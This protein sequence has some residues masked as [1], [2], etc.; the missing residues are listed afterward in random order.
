VKQSQLKIF[1]GVFLLLSLV[2]IA[3]L[4]RLNFSYDFEQFFPEGDEDLEFF[5]EFRERFEAD[6]NFMLFA[7]KNE[8]GIFEGDFLSKFEN[9]TKACSDL[10]FVTDV[11]SLA[12]LKL[13]TRTPFGFS[14]VSLI[15]PGEPSKYKQDQERIKKYDELENVLYS[16]DLKSVVI[17]C[18]TTDSVGIGKSTELIPAIHELFEPYDF[19]SYYLLGRANFQYVLVKMQKREFLISSIVSFALLILFMFI[20]FKEPLG[21]LI[22]AVSVIVSMLLF[23]GFMLLFDREFNAISALYPILLLI[24]S[25]SDVVHLLSKYIDEIELGKTNAEAINVTVKEIGRA[26]F[27]TSTTTAAGF[28]SLST[29]K[30]I[31]IREF[32]VNAAVGVLIAYITVLLFTTGLLSIFGNKRKMVIR[33]NKGFWERLMGWFSKTSLNRPRLIVWSIVVVLLFCAYG[34][35]QVSTNYS[36]AKNLPKADNI[37]RDFAFFE[38]HFGGFRP[39]EFSIRSKNGSV[40]EFEQ[41]EEIA[42]LEQHVKK[43]P[44]IE[45]VASVVQPFR[46]LNMALRNQNVAFNKL[47]SD[48]LAYSQQRQLIS[49]FAGENLG[50]LVSKDQTYGRI[51]TRVG[52]IGADSIK[53]I[54][55]R[56]D[57]W[58]DSNL[59]TSKIEVVQT[60]TGLVLD[61]N[62]EYVR[63]SILIGLLSAIILVSIIMGFLFRNWKMMVIALIPNMIPLIFSAALLGFAGVELEAGISIIFAI[64]FGIAVDD[65]IHFLSRYKLCRLKGLDQ[66]TAIEHTFRQTGKAITI[67]TVI[68]FIGFSV[69]FF[70]GYRPTFI[71]GCLIGITLI[72]AWLVDL[73]LIPILLRKLE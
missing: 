40:L 41:M 8:E 26:I 28:L 20:L 50:N 56:L 60:G 45:V 36:I 68:L 62:S 12:N 46:W 59:D 67:T 42:K 49:T 3:F 39:L 22:T 25:T 29:S 72:G 4:P 66:E 23:L 52:D 54:N 24:V 38:N 17:F 7:L 9:V 64:V 19:D 10:P 16:S 15:H 47:T 58:I 33:Q 5:Q 31:P 44:H 30:L 32:G 55:A 53:N 27:L 71:V 51:S 61:K 48:S 73:L 69:L 63:N 34:I 11:Q 18:K 1:V 43:E 13:P 14:T 70:S 37:K 35:S 57:D 2:T 21:I 6:D 65:T